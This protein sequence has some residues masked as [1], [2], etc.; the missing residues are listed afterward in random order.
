MK[1]TRRTAGALAVLLAAFGVLAHRAEAQEAPVVS[2]YRKDPSV[3]LVARFPSGLPE[4]SDLALSRCTVIPSGKVFLD[5]KVKLRRQGTSAEFRGRMP[6]LSPASNVELRVGDRVALVFEI[7]GRP[8]APVNVPIGPPPA[9]VAAAA[10]TADVPP[11]APVTAPA[12]VAAAAP[13][14]APEPTAMPTAA[15]AAQVEPSPAAV[16][17]PPPVLGG[18]EPASGKAGVPQVPTPSRTAAALPTSAAAVTHTPSEETSTGSSAAVAAVSAPTPAAGE[19]ARRARGGA[20]PAVARPAWIR[21]APWVGGGVGIAVLTLIG[22]VAARGKPK[23]ADGRRNRADGSTGGLGLA[24]QTWS[25]TAPSPAG[26]GN[27]ASDAPPASAEQLGIHVESLIARG[28]LCDIFL[29]R[30]GSDRRRCA[31]K[32]LRPEFR[33]SATL[34]EGLVREG[35]IIRE[36][37]AAYP[38]QVFITLFDQGFFHDSGTEHPYLVLEYVE[39][40]NLRNFVRQHG[41]MESFA[42][43]SAMRALADGLARVHECGFVHGDISP[44][45]VLWVSNAALR[46]EGE[47]RFRLIDFG[48]SRKFDLDVKAE[49]IAGKPAFLSPEQTTGAAA[50]PASDMYS[51]GMVLFFLLAGSAAFQSDNPLDILRMHRENSLRFPPSFPSEICAAIEALCEK[52]PDLRPSAGETVDI[53]DG[54]LSGSRGVA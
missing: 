12:V 45:N 22:V 23:P 11:S 44:E 53:L 27:G 43:L 1:R 8:V 15:A 39:G 14:A 2:A 47:P 17:E 36:L 50:T 42:A 54:L 25:A 52:N 24:R 19:D 34:S 21:Y 41:P 37:N 35:E 49:E 4:S 3:Y 46:R 29:A 16:F 9:A 13:T 20:E 30:R 5:V 28:G 6:V 18:L 7:D 38:G 32:V 33:S 51:L 48:D 40:P 31:L 26:V 10:P